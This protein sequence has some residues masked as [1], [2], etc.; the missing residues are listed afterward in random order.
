MAIKIPLQLLSIE[1]DG[2]HL[3]VKVKVNGKPALMIVDTGASRTVFDKTQ[4]ANFLQLEEVAEHDRV[5]TGLG[6]SNMI[7]QVVTLGR[8]SLGKLQ[9]KLFPAVV[10]DL[11]HVNHTY[12]AL[13]FAPIVGV[14]G[15]DVLVAH[16][17]V[18]DFV[19]KSMAL[20]PLKA[21]KKAGKKAAKKKVVKKS[22]KK[23]AKKT[24]KKKSRK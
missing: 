11:Q 16:K 9:L 3:Q 10:L 2:F 13:G 14:L 6:T 24:A 22:V 4:I 8:F 5:S 19:K 21:G 23:A 18:I 12:D 15:C 17:A 7:S 20:Q 1:G